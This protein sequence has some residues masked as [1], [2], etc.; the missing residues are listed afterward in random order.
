LIVLNPYEGENDASQAV[1]RDMEKQDEKSREARRE[2][3]E[4]EW[5]RRS[6]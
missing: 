3:R 4:W 6:R 2:Y 5:G 1:K